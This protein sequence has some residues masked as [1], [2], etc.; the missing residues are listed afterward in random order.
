MTQDSTTGLRNGSPLANRFR[1]GVGDGRHL[2]AFS[3][4]VTICARRLDYIL[5]R[6]NLLTLYAHNF[7]A[8]YAASEASARYEFDRHS[9]RE[10]EFMSLLPTLFPFP[11]EFDEAE[12]LYGIPVMA[13]GYEHWNMEAEDYSTAGLVI[14][15]LLGHQ[16]PEQWDTSRALQARAVSPERL[17]IL[18]QEY[19]LSHPLRGLGTLLRSLDFQSGNPF[20]DTVPESPREDFEWTQESIDSLKKA[21]EEIVRVQQLDKALSDWLEA[22][23]QHFE[24]LLAL[25]NR[26]DYASEPMLLEREAGKPLV[27]TITAQEWVRG[28]TPLSREPIDRWN[29]VTDGACRA[30]SAISPLA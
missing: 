24:A 16:E 14:A 4:D 25:W 29:S 6:A 18:C 10:W 20:L 22:D 23:P 11:E 27:T 5:E 17:D 8:A 3:F 7:P 12:L 21:G 26:A 30:A 9:A 1:L 13:L 19:E 15:S 28:E 2:E